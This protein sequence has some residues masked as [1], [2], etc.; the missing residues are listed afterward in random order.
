MKLAREIRADRLSAG[1]IPDASLDVGGVRR[2]AEAVLR[3]QEPGADEHA[4]IAICLDPGNRPPPGPPLARRIT[5]EIAPHPLLV[6]SRID[7]HQIGRAAWRGRGE[8]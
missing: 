6:A 5:V 7:G 3:A 1:G 2:P 4:Q 8:M